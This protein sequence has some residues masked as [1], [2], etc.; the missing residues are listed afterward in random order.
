MLK[1]LIEGEA[2]S[3]LNSSGKP[4]LAITHVLSLISPDKKLISGRIAFM[5]TIVRFAN[6]K[7]Q[8]FE[9]PQGLV[10]PGDWDLPSHLLNQQLETQKATHEFCLEMIESAEMDS[11]IKKAWTEVLE[12]KNC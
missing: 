9:S 1:L 3:N 2:V 6:N 7:L 8:E 10:F 5:Q 12:N 11:S 4:E